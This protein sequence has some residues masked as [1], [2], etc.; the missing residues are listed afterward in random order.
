MK[1]RRLSG[2]AKRT[3]R[4]LFGVFPLL[5][6][7]NKVRHPLRAFR[8]LMVERTETRRLIRLLGGPV[9]G[10]IVTI[11]PT[12][13]REQLLR[14]AVE[15]ALQQRIGS[16]KHRVLVVDD[17]GS[18]VADF[19]DRRVTTVGLSRN[20]GAAGVVRNIGLRISRSPFVALLDDDNR[21]LP[22]HLATSIEALQ[23]GADLAYTGMRR[24]RSDGTPIDELTVP[25]D[26]RALR[27]RAFVDSS[28]MSL[29]RGRR[30]WFSRVPRSRQTTPG[31]DWEFVYRLS[32][33]G[34]IVHVPEVTVE[35]LVH[36]GSY[37]TDWD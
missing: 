37:F 27:E 16:L 8:L 20:T 7:R 32:R 31:E 18:Q 35:Y 4:D 14:D 13:R 25:F 24:I 5:E 6:L 26:R 10:D 11:I 12:Y 19:A 21:W 17:G 15:S 9:T 36:G 30:T 29:R 1:S 23:A 2:A 34:N 33:R 3:V 28:T 22:N